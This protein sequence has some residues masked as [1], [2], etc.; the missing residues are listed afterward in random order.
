[1]RALSGAAENS[2]SEFTYSFLERS[3]SSASLLYHRL[4][5]T[6]TFPLAGRGNVALNGT[7]PFSFI[8]SFYQ[9]ERSHAGGN[10]LS[11]AP[12]NPT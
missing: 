1:M 7:P 2:R 4:M 10:V 3:A 5:R 12:L 6:S 8:L 11:Q 9:P